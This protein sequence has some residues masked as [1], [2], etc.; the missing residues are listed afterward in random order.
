MCCTQ[1]TADLYAPGLQIAHLYSQT[2]SR[3]SDF[4]WLC[5]F[6]L[7]NK[8]AWLAPKQISDPDGSKDRVEKVATWCFAAS[9]CLH[10]RFSA[11]WENAIAC[12]HNLP[13]WTSRQALAYNV[14]QVELTRNPNI[15]CLRSLCGWWTTFPSLVCFWA[16]TSQNQSG[17]KAPSQMAFKI[18]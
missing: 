8:P 11:I 10:R 6:R 17:P 16:A 9:C 7:K 12:E 13:A 5:S 18:N 4:N 2:E 15:I 3:F 14:L 1:R